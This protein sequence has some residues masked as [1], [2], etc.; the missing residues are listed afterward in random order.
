MTFS[1][2]N[3]NNIEGAAELIYQTDLEFFSFAFGK[4]KKKAFR[5]IIAL[6]ES[7]DNV[8]SRKHI[9][10]VT[11]KKDN[12]LGIT[13]CYQGDSIDEKKQSNIFVKKSSV[14]DLIK[15]ALIIDPI[16]KK[17]L[18][19]S[20]SKSDIYISNI[21]VFEQ[22]RGQGVGTFIIKNIFELAK[23]KSCNRAVLHVSDVN[24]RAKKLYSSLGFT[25]FERKKTRYLGIK[26]GTYC[27]EYHI[28]K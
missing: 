28:E 23:Q 21:S 16:C 20:L 8:F 14:W 11:D 5:K 13:V 27:M 12:L 6:I 4:N 9:Y 3:N 26:S 22:Y 18:E 10:Q 25:V 2:L 15:L 24:P 1:I 19:T 17:I 7:E